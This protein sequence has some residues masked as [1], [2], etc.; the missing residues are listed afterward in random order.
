MPARLFRVSFTGELGFE[1]NVPAGAWPR[2]LG[3][4]LCAPARPFG[5]APYGTETMHVLRAEK[6]Y[7][8]VGQET[9]G[10]VTP[11]DLGL[12]WADRQGEAR[13]RRQALAGAARHAEAGPQAARRPAHR[14]IR[15]AV[16]EE[17]AQIV[18]DPDSAGADADARPRHLV[19]LERK[20]SQRSIALALVAGGRAPH[21]RRRC[22]CRCPDG[23]IEV[24]GGR[25]GL[26][27]PGRDAARWLAAARRSPSP[28][29]P[30]RRAWRSAAASGGH[31]R[32]AARIGIDASARRPA[33]RPPKAR[34]PRCGSVR[35]S[36]C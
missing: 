33:A 20:R 23:A 3:G 16:L 30:R 27:R 4:G 12:G 21:G 36:G 24:D 26:L 17:G 31:R 9:D 14:R 2:G 29:S 7:I 13:F 32:W 18:A 5:I 28:R 34:A 25:A 10:T 11:D 8:I 19:L 22:S 35:T 15:S 1:I 6:G